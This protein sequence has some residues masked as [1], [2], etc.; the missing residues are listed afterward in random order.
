M[1]KSGLTPINMQCN[2]EPAPTAAHTYE[3]F[4]ECPASS[5]LPGNLA[6]WVTSDEGSEQASW[7]QCSPQGG[8]MAIGLGHH[9]LACLVT[10]QQMTDGIHKMFGEIKQPVFQSASFYGLTRSLTNEN[11]RKRYKLSCVP[12]IKYL[13]PAK[14]WNFWKFICIVIKNYIIYLC[15]HSPTLVFIHIYWIITSIQILY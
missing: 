11:G 3:N 13:F 12:L 14:V 10:W 5:E 9:V 2:G 6:A 15:I 1:L 4:L 8:E 7:V